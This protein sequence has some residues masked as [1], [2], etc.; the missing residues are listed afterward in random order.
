MYNTTVHKSTG[1][2]P[3]SLVFVDEAVYPI[4][5][6]FSKP[7]D[8]ELTVYEY[9]QLLDEKF[10]EAHMC[11]RVQQRQK[12][13]FFKRTYGKPY[14]KDDKMWLFLPQLAKSKKF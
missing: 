10:R 4:D 6:M 2:S 3:F 9:T 11:A 7:P 1:E 14:Q 13:K 12:D 8:T 5:L